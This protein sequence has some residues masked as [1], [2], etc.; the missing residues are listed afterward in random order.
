MEPL[1]PEVASPVG[2]GRHAVVCA[3]R[4][5]GNLDDQ[6]QKLMM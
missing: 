1:R 6:A 3:Q 5:D 2:L 4:S